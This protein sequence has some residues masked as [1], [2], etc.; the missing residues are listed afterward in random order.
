MAYRLDGRD[1]VF[2]GPNDEIILMI[3]PGRQLAILHDERTLL[4]HG[5]MRGVTAYA[6]NLRASFKAA[7]YQDMGHDL[8]VIGIDVEGL[9]EE[10]IE[11]VNACIFT[12][13]R[14]LQLKD[15]LAARKETSPTLC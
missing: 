4:K 13:G 8:V 10:V 1:L 14:V 15:R 5:D 7:G 6:D 12:T 3:E 2:D 11:E 9:T